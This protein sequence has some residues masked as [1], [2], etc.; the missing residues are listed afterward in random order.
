[1]VV[2]HF[3]SVV[4]R[5]FTQALPPSLRRLAS[6]QPLLLSP[7]AIVI[8]YRSDSQVAPVQNE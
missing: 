1:V 6:R 2:P 7:H 8:G 4:A 3:L 5:D